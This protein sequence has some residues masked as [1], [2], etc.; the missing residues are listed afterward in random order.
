MQTL[1]CWSYD[2]STLHTPWVQ[3]RASGTWCRWQV[4][5]FAALPRAYKTSA[6]FC[7]ILHSLSRGV[8]DYIRSLTYV[9]LNSCSKVIEQSWMK[10]KNLEKEQQWAHACSLATPGQR[11]ESQRREGDFFYTEEF[12]TC[13][14]HSHPN[15][16]VCAVGWD[17]DNSTAFWVFISEHLEH[18]C[19]QN[20]P[21]EQEA[22]VTNQQ[23]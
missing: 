13:I 3:K 4:L 7:W 16:F 21:G 17:C 10:E 22:T 11:L 14:K 20:W 12:I 19:S 5:S 8:T 9:G 2:H 15:S 6:S 23:P 1:I 18:K